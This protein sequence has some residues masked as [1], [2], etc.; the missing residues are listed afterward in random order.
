M[1]LPLDPLASLST[2][3]SLAQTHAQARPPPPSY[4]SVLSPP[5]VDLLGGA[6]SAGPALLDS[7]F[8]NTS[9]SSYSNSLPSLADESGLPADLASHPHDMMPTE[10]S[11]DAVLS[12]THA[13]VFLFFAFFVCVLVLVPCWRFVQG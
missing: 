7:L 13:K 2:Q 1:D 6:I 9:N 3:P 10:L 12:V 5:P 4:D 8:G 11:A